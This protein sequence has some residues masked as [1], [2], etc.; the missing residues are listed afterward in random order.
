MVFQW[1]R[2]KYDPPG[3]VCTHRNRFCV[4]FLCFFLQNLKSEKKFREVSKRLIR[5]RQNSP[6]KAPSGQLETP[7][8][9][10]NFQIR[11]ITSTFLPKNRILGWWWWCGRAW[12]VPPNNLDVLHISIFQGIDLKHRFFFW[13]RQTVKRRHA[14]KSQAVTPSDAHSLKSR[15][16]VAKI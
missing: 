6:Q 4:F 1:P 10:R 7:H 15:P 3:G 2:L 11:Q 8:N 12:V 14:V 13:P 5:G 9:L 16:R